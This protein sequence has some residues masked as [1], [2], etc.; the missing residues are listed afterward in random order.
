MHLLSY[1]CNRYAWQ[2]LIALILPVLCLLHISGCYSSSSNDSD[3]GASDASSDENKYA[4]GSSDS[5]TDVDSDTDIDADGDSDTDIDADADADLIDGGN[6]VWVKQAGSIGTDLARAIALGTDNDFYITGYYN[7][8]STFGR[9][10]EKESVLEPFGETESDIFIAK[11]LDNGNHIWSIRAGGENDDEGKDITSSADGS[12]YI[13]GFFEGTAAFGDN[14]TTLKS[15]GKSDIFIAKYNKEGDFL[16]ATGGGGQ[17]NDEGNSIA[18][19]PDNTIVVAGTLAGQAVFGDGEASETTLRRGFFITKYDSSGV[20]LWARGNGQDGVASANSVAVHE[21]GSIYATG[22][23]HRAT[24]GKGEPTEKTIE[25]YGEDYDIFVAKYNENG[26]FLWAESA[27]GIPDTWPGPI[28]A[29]HSIALL[30]DGSALIAGEYSGPSVF[31]EGLPNETTLYEDH[32]FFARY[33][34]DGNLKWAKSSKRTG[35]AGFDA[36]YA[37]SL[38]GGFFLL[39][40]TFYGEISFNNVSDVDISVSSYGH[41]DLYLGKFDLDGNAIWAKSAGSEDDHDYVEDI[42]FLPDNSAIITG[43][44]SDEAVFGKNEAN[45]E[46]ITSEGGGD[47]FIAK[48]SP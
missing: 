7:N 29:G 41:G 46:Q 43:R 42:M 38:Q 48:Y 21:D 25:K 17:E 5:A 31:G 33:G 30:N 28:E 22:Y 47:I 39:A 6:L 44:F 35:P 34:V 45:Q 27:G 26:D 19:S 16:W 18:V 24:F 40:G 4:D 3:G 2:K 11:Y 13:T 8:T 1:I 15:S 12:L 9:D 37:V 20:L 14:E 36:G 23:L 32:T 10:E